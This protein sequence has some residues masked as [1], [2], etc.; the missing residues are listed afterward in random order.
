MW[1]FSPNL[2]LFDHFANHFIIVAHQ[3][4][5]H[6]NTFSTVFF[7]MTNKKN[8]SNSAWHDF[9]MLIQVNISHSNKKESKNV[10]LTFCA[11][12]TVVL[13]MFV[14]AAKKT[15]QNN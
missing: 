1:S 7:L 12:F 4:F 2:N 3:V 15:K 9:I 11:T 6:I 5:V 10:V 14:P 13:F 8:E